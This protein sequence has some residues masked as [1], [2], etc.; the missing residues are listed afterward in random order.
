MN[1]LSPEHLWDKFEQR[2]MLSS[3]S[4]NPHKRTHV[5]GLQAD[6]VL[7]YRVFSAKTAG[8]CS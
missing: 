2:L 7:I 4:K 8:K 5:F 1:K 6:F 3:Y